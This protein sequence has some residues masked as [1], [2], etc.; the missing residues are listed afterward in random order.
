MKRLILVL[1]TAAM[2]LTACGK[3]ETK[4]EVPQETVQD[5]TCAEAISETGDYAIVCEWEAYAPD[6]ERLTFFVENHTEEPLETGV[7]FR[8]ERQEANGVWSA[9]PMVEN[10]GWV[11]LGLSVPAGGRVPLDCWFSVY[12]YDFARGGAY[13]IVKE[14][15][16]QLVAG[17]FRMAEG[18]GISAERPY[19]FAPLEELPEDF[20]ASAAVGNEV[21]FT[22]EESRN[23]EA[24]EKFL[25]KSG[26]GVDCQLRTVQ[27]YGEGVPM[28]IDV[29]YENDHFLWR[30]WSQGEITERRFS[31]V[32]TDGADLFLS[33]GV[34]WANTERFESDTA[35]LI[36][37][38]VTGAMLTEVERQAAV[39]LLSNTARYKIWSDDG[40]CSAALTED[41]AEFSVGWQKQGEGS[42]GELF[43]LQGRNGPETAVTALQWQGS[44]LL[45]TCETVRDNGR[46]RLIFDTESWSLKDSNG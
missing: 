33:N 32:V 36:P 21:V 6:V 39:R 7:D 46:A 26:S 22:G 25:E 2:M 10:A 42:R 27:D 19:G 13:R 18:S 14:L 41:P 38:G 16:G 1:L 12:D 4:Q 9:V 23:L 35:F 40:T 3:Q 45:L 5:P 43:D 11:A 8:L 15:N 17:E 44:D 31:Y 20:G 37:Q 30:M 24:V 29:I 28:V 34:D